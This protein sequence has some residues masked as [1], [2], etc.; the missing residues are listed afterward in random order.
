[1]IT[2]FVLDEKTYKIWPLKIQKNNIWPAMGRE[3]RT[4]ALFGN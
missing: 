3:L 4:P 2:S 1:M